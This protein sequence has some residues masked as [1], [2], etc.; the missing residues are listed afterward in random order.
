[1]LDSTRCATSE[2]AE[3]VLGWRPRPP[4]EAI[5]ATAESLLRFGIA[6]G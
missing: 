3:R 5:L 6:A 1:L 2:K 4:Q